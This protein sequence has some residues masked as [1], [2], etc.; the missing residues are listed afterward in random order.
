MK[1]RRRQAALLARV[2]FGHVQ[3]AFAVQAVLPQIKAQAFSGY[4][5]L[6]KGS[7][8]G[9]PMTDTGK[10]LT[11]WADLDAE[12]RLKLQRDYQAELDTQPLTCSLDEK[13][14]RFT[15]W[16]AERGVS[17]TMEDLRRR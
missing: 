13:M 2:R 17:F 8:K 14:D 7:S 6:S 4:R 11:P 9:P 3:S 12:A 10:N 1:G 5:L 15:K 16:L